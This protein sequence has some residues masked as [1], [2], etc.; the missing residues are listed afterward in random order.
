MKWLFVLLFVVGCADNGI[1]S[2]EPEYY[3]KFVSDLD[4]IKTYPNIQTHKQLIVETN[5]LQS[6]K[7]KWHSN[8]LL[9][10]R[11]INHIDTVSTVNCCSYPYNG[12]AITI[13]GA[14][15]IMKGDTATV[16]AYTVVRGKFISD[17]TKI[18]IY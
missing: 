18:I 17:T 3:I 5:L 9:Q 2:P 4:S 11:T 6:R 8:I 12:R 13:F 1:V 14:F 15:D 10:V 7:I 16:I